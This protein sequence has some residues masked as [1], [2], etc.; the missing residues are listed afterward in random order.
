MNR[1]QIYESFHNDM[2]NADTQEIRCLHDLVH[3][4]CFTREAGVEFVLAVEKVAEERG[5]SEA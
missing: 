5:V 2:E 4:G 3:D 1:H